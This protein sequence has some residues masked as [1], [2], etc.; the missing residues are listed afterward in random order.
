MSARRIDPRAVKLNRTY[1]VGELAA[2]LRVHKNTVRSWQREGLKPLD[3]GRPVLFHGS[4]LRVFLASR[5]A[6][7]KSPCPPG[8]IYCFKCRAPR[9]PA[10]EMVDYIPISATGG[11]IRALCATCDT[12]MHRR[13][14]MAVLAS[15]MPGCDVQIVE[16]SSRL[17]GR[18]RPSLSCDSRRKAKPR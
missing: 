3:G 10:L 14:K 6:S 17:M 1:D 2:L 18:P 9:A 15:I 5:N 11:N 16:A 13:A 8:T 7:R 12:M 4:G